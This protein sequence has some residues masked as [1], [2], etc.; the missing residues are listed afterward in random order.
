[1]FKYIL[2]LFIL[3]FCAVTEACLD[4]APYR[5]MLTELEHGTDGERALAVRIQAGE[6]LTDDEKTVVE[7]LH[8]KQCR[9]MLKELK[10]NLKLVLS[11]DRSRSMFIG[12]CMDSVLSLSDMVEGMS[13]NRALR[14]AE[15]T[16]PITTRENIYARFHEDPVLTWVAEDADNF[17]KPTYEIFN[18]GDKVSESA[19]IKVYARGGLNWMQRASPAEIERAVVALFDS[20]EV[21]SHFT[22]VV[23]DIPVDSLK[24]MRVGEHGGLSYAGD[25]IVEVAP[26]TTRRIKNKLSHVNFVYRVSD[27]SFVLMDHSIDELLVF[28]TDKTGIEKLLAFI[29]GNERNTY[30]ANIRMYF[31]AIES[32]KGVLAMKELFMNLYGSLPSMGEKLQR[33]EIESWKLTTR[34]RIQ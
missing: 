6:E 31:E 12:G 26:G 2:I 13:A 22:G 1:M 16:Y 20:D 30:E 19:W 18:N 34:T 8:I 17:M 3:Y 14:K 27:K 28:S 33:V 10:A 29:Q 9:Q 21:I 24:Q 4:K 23:D 15:R 32:N 11:G 5:R 25:Y 7:E